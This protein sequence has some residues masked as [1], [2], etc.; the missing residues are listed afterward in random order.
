MSMACWGPAEGGASRRGFPPAS[1]GRGSARGGSVRG[2]SAWG[3][4]ARRGA[5]RCGLV[6]AGSARRGVADGASARVGSARG[7][8]AR[9]GS[10]RAGSGAGASAISGSAG[11]ILARL[12]PCV[13]DFLLRAFFGSAAS[14]APVADEDV[15]L[16][17]V[18]STQ[19]RFGHL[20]P[21]PVGGQP[22]GR[23]THCVVIW[24]RSRGERGG[25]RPNS[26]LQVRR[27]D[28]CQCW[29]WR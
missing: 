22:G 7:G 1:D 15:N 12:L 16:S 14:G 9:D 27:R 2:F 26:S 18:S 13:P 21:L 6:G 10:A 5:A 29:R 19:S 20:W 3:A 11:R 24:C 28:S 25:A 23:G 17:I 8:S 4:A